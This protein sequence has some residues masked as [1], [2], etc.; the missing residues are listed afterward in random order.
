MP[1][2]SYATLVMLSLVLLLL[3]LAFGDFTAAVALAL[4]IGWVTGVVVSAI[5][6]AAL[7]WKHS[8][9]ERTREWLANQARLAELGW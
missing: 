5:V 1:F 2:R 3:A 4:M 9:A 8:R 7:A 6:W